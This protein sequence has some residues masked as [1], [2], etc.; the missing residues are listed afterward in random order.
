MR[1]L[2]KH[3]HPALDGMEFVWM[4]ILM[5]IWTNVF[6]QLIMIYVMIDHRHIWHQLHNLLE[7]SI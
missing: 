2:M 6:V 3:V 5:I 7:K 1:Q 4:K